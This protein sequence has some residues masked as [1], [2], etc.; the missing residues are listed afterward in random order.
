MVENQE[1]IEIKTE[2]L[3]S[4]KPA[5]NLKDHDENPSEENPIEN[6]STNSNDEVESKE[7]HR[8]NSRASYS[9]DF[10]GQLISKCLI[11]VI[12]WTK[13]ATKIL[14]IRI[15]AIIGN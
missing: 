7:D 12:V 1:N 14:L 9:N 6:P 8:K 3:E 15:S 4:E 10:K 13:I 11:G 5:G 2:I